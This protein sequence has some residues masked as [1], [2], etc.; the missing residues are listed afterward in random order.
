MKKL[1]FPYEK[2]INE[3]SDRPASAFEGALRTL[4]ILSPENP[5]IGLTFQFPSVI[6]TSVINIKQT[7]SS[8]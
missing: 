2:K 8:G 4:R 3:Q 6:V 1:E 7:S 5:D